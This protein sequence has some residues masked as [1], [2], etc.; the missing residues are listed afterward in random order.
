M[1]VRSGKVTYNGKGV[2]DVTIKFIGENG[3]NY[4]A[5]TDDDGNYEKEVSYNWSGSIT[6]IK[7]R[8]QFIRKEKKYT[9]VTSHHEE[10]N[11]EVFTILQRRYSDI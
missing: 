6:P 5:L 4:T 11:Y 2:G 9:K 1:M 10:Q 8:H 3:D 7:D